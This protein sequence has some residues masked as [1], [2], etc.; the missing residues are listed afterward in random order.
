MK[1]LLWLSLLALIM[2]CGGG[3]GSKDDG[4]N[5]GGEEPCTSSCDGDGDR[6]DATVQRI[7]L[8]G[9]AVKGLAR[10]A[11]LEAFVLQGS[12]FKASP[13]VSTKTGQLGRYQVQ[14]PEV[15]NNYSG[16]IKMVLSYLDQTS[17][18][19]CDDNDGCG[20]GVAFG[21]WYTMPVDFEMKS[22]ANVG[23]VT[24]DQGY[25]LVNLSALTTL[26]ANYVEDADS[27]NA[28]IIKQTNNQVRAVFSLPASV[29]LASTEPSVITDEDSDGHKVYGAINAAFQKVANDNSSSIND[30][31]SAFTTQLSANDGQVYVKAPADTDEPSIEELTTAAVAL[32]VL[33]G[34]D[35]DE[36]EAVKTQAQAATAGAVT[37]IN[38]PSISAGDDQT[39]N[40]GATVT[41]PVTFL[42]GET[43]A[44]PVYA[45]QVLSGPLSLV[46]NPSAST[47]TLT[48]T[49]PDEGGLIRLRVIIESDAGDD[50][51]I[52]NV[53]VNPALASG[54]TEESGAYKLS[55]VMS[56]LIGEND[57]L[58]ASIALYL[59]EL[60]LNFNGDGTGAISADAS[61][62]WYEYNSGYNLSVP[63]T[64]VYDDEGRT[65]E[66]GVNGEAFSIDFSHLPHGGF[67][68]SLP[69]ELD[70]YDTEAE[71][72]I[73]QNYY[74]YQLAPGLYSGMTLQAAK[75][76]PVNN[77]QVGTEPSAN[78]FNASQVNLAKDT[79]DV[80]V[81]TDFSDS[82]N[83]QYIG[84]E[85]ANY[86]VPF[87]SF[88]DVHFGVHRNESTFN[89]DGTAL[90]IVNDRAVI[91]G[92]INANNTTVERPFE[93]IL[94]E[95]TFANDLTLFTK[96]NGRADK[97]LTD[98]PTDRLQVTE[99]SEDGSVFMV[100]AQ[101][102]QNY[103][104]ASTSHLNNSERVLNGSRMGVY[105]EKPSTTISIDGKEL[106]FHL[107]QADLDA[108]DASGGDVAPQISLTLS[109]V[110][111]FING[112]RVVYE[113]ERQP[114]QLEYTNGVVDVDANDA[115][116]G[117]ALSYGSLTNDEGTGV[118]V[119]NTSDVD[120]CFQLQDENFEICVSETDVV[121]GRF[122]EQD[123]NGTQAS[124]SVGY[125]YGKVIG[126]FTASTGFSSADINGNSFTY[127]FPGEGNATYSFAN[128]GTGSVNWPDANSDIFDWFVD[129]KNRL[130]IEYADETDRYTLISGTESNGSVT[131]EIKTGDG[132][133]SIENT[134]IWSLQ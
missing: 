122:Y 27:I 66:S 79:S 9:L 106:Q 129:A 16:P 54:G 80:V 53:T 87:D 117:V 95:E 101:Q 76:Y 2:A 52:I 35:L 25:T 65:E 20:D 123:V 97:G 40:A 3:G 21:D 127:V 49:A 131:L 120:G 34:D 60:N 61:A 116:D 30:V 41:L 28:D 71:E 86:Y 8:T 133:Y 77:G 90:N 6:D 88:Q 128:D 119:S 94:E 63:N 36:V 57:F 48:F 89:A 70:V 114:A 93:L 46:G 104:N 26:A 102:Y 111:M 43:V 56:E 15:L 50:N 112:T 32:N 62:Q 5:S 85:F 12:A 100:A 78:V 44:N 98:A 81:S 11:K 14:L 130:I 37:N 107:L 110:R 69:V 1:H 55:E 47:N 75:L 23:N 59:E 7:S 42:A 19:Q 29:D 109:K 4:G 125:L 91:Y 113:V 132:N 99:A 134:G 17:Q 84:F 74:F 38:P 103:D 58:G 73:G 92:S 67:K 24:N 96:V 13:E 45:W 31:I 18:L 64:L 68:F 10:N 72:N 108:P 105:I 121:V 39:V 126:D 118:V 83:R 22:I 51:D 115:V 33:S 124:Y 82:A